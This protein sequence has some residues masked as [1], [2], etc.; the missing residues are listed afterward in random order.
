MAYKV[1]ILGEDLIDL[2]EDHLGNVYENIKEDDRITKIRLHYGD[3]VEITIGEEE[4]N[5]S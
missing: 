1:T 3:K 2:L 5:V 4:E